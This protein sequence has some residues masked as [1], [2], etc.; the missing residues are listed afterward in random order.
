M[1]LGA[2]QGQDLN[3]TKALLD[4]ARP[5]AVNLSWATAHMLQ[6]SRFMTK[7]QLLQEAHDLAR[8][9][10]EINSRMAQ[11][12][13]SLI[14]L[15]LANKIVHVLTH[16]NT[17]ALACAAVGTALGVIV[18]RYKIRPNLFVWVDE[19][20]PRLQG[21]RLTAYELSQARI[22][23]AVI[24]DSAAASLM[25]AGKVDYVVFGA[26][27]IASN[28]DVVNKIGSYALSVLA[29]HHNIPVYCVAPTS[30]ID[31]ACPVGSAIKVEERDPDEI[32]VING[33]RVAP[34]DARAFN[35]AFDM[36]PNSLISSIVTEN[37]VCSPP[38]SI[39][40]A[41]AVSA[42]RPSA[43]ATSQAQHAQHAESAFRP[44]TRVTAPSGGGWSS[45]SQ[46]EPSQTHISTRVVSVVAPFFCSL[47]MMTHM[48]HAIDTHAVLSLD[49]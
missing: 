20:R 12:G 10:V 15:S 5:T 38:Y 42:S 49:L 25:Q 17:G 4:A 40:L 2:L 44:S 26:D 48:Y 22:P 6:C 7:E 14:P 33:V 11:N 45:M 28:G 13:A 8:R 36:T 41:R 43:A 34:S 35:P 31:L 39:S 18:A 29:S 46:A 19:T 9:D 1:A 32:L 16:C 37:G 47:G 23:Y 30:T 27:R 3:K 24:A 21:S